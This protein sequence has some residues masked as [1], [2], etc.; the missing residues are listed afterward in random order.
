MSEIKYPHV[1][2]ELTDGNAMA[3]IGAASKA[4]RRAGVPEAELVEFRTEARSGDYDHV[5]QTIMA[6]VDVE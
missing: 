6:W 4:L 1:T 2:V 3:M 5:L